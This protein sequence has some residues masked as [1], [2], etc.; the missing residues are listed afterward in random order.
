MAGHLG[1]GGILLSDLTDSPQTLT[2][3]TA[4]FCDT[5]KCL[6]DASKRTA[7]NEM[8]EARGGGARA[9]RRRAC[10]AAARVRGASTH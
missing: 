6:R 4:Y 1:G 9:R 2:G 3:D 5:C 7:L 10:A 8:P